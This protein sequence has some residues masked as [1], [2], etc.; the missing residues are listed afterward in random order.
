MKK[1]SQSSENLKEDRHVLPK[2]KEKPKEKSKT[3]P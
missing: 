1:T 3:E 2:N